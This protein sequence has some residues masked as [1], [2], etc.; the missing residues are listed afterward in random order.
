MA[1]E[2]RWSGKSVLQN[3]QQIKE[4]K[5]AFSL[6]PF[7]FPHKQHVKTGASVNSRRF[8]PFTKAGDAVLH[9]YD[10]MHGVNVRGGKKRCSLVI[11][12]GEN[13]DSVASKTVPW[14]IREA[15]MSV[16]GTSVHASFLYGV[17]A[18]NGSYGFD[19]DLEVAKKY[20]RWASERGHALSAYC[21]SLRLFK[22]SYTSD[23]SRQTDLQNESLLLMKLAAEISSRT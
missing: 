21:L 7:S 4:H 5:R 2:K 8:V 9:R 22:E 13:E 19:K 12:F 15:C 3:L 14:V 1:N 10:V 11:W 23:K 18:Q 6:I 17:N 20:Y 16:T